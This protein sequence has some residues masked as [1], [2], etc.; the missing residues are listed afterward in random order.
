LDVGTQ[1]TREKVRHGEDLVQV[2][3]QI[4]AVLRFR[5]ALLAQGHAVRYNEFDGGHDYA[6]RN[7]TLVDAL[8]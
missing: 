5:D 1:E 6:S 4:D 7:R 3:S 2:V 8:K